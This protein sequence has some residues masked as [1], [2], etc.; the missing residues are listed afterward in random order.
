V[1]RHAPLPKE[2]RGGGGGGMK[3]RNG[4]G[5][6]LPGGGNR[7]GSCCRTQ[8]P[9]Q[10]CRLRRRRAQGRRSPARST[11]AALS[12]NQVMGTCCKTPTCMCGL[13]PLIMVGPTKLPF[14]YPFFTL[15]LRPSKT[16]CAPSSAADWISASTCQSVTC[17]HSF[18][19]LE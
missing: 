11:A 9:H 19:R 6:H 14:S 5:K 1:N 4:G 17:P 12:S 8:S 10:K 18:R 3:R 15:G 2:N 16:I 13:T 7:R